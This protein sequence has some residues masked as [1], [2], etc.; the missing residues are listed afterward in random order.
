M[1]S[2]QYNL[3]LAKG[4]CCSVAGKVTT[5]LTETNSRFIVSIL[6]VSLG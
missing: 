5:G 2:K 3:I 6:T 4:Q 1:S